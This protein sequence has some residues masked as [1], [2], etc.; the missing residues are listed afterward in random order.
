MKYATIPLD[1]V[2]ALVIEPSSAFGIAGRHEI[3]VLS[4]RSSENAWGAHLDN[5]VDGC[6]VLGFNRIILDLEHAK[7]SSSFLIACLA[8]AWQRLISNNGTLVL[9][10]LAPASFELLRG[11]VNPELFNIFDT[12]DDC[13]DWLEQEGGELERSFPRAAQCSACGAGGQV[14]SRGEHLCTE[15]GMTYLVTERGE[16]PF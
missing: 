14:G 1:T 10:G 15:C 7:V 8:S 16:L 6:L 3:A 4:V 9:Y 12:L 11:L 13:V 5:V 2:N